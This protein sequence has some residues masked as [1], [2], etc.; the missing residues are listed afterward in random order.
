[1]SSFPPSIAR[2]LRRV[3]RENLDNEDFLLPNHTLMAP[4]LAHAVQKS[5][6]REKD[7][8]NTTFSIPV[9]SEAAGFLGFMT[10]TIDETLRHLHHDVD[11]IFRIGESFT[12]AVRW[13]RD[14]PTGESELTERISRPLSG[15]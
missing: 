12:L 2:A 14:N 15:C 10:L 7:Y 6:Y 8:L 13:D 5:F 11:E 1:M 4:Y 3:Q 9:E